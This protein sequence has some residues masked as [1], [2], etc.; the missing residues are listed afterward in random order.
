[1]LTR[2]QGRRGSGLQWFWVGT[3]CV[4][5][6][7]FLSGK[8]L[9]QE[10]CLGKD[11][12]IFLLFGGHS[13]DIL[14]VA[15][16]MAERRSSQILRC[17]YWASL[18]AQWLRIHLPMQGTQVR[19]LAREY[20]TCRRATKPVHHNYWAH[21]PQLLKPVHLEPVLRNKRS[22]PVRSLCTATKSSPR[23]PQLEKACAQQRRPNTAKKF[24]K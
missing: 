3:Q 2:E 12:T 5:L 18:V 14:P 15:G 1:M 4:Y 8:L 6:W 24:F 19:A 9:W 7:G 22:H 17:R 21:M 13:M 10:G 11:A 20:P 16:K 23:S